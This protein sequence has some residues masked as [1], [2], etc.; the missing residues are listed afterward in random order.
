MHRRSRFSPTRPLQERL[1]DFAASAIQE[2]AEMPNG[3]EREEM[4]KKVHKAKAASEIELWANTP[5]S[6]PPK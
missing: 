5:G 6:Q 4:L 1:A 2:A 3:R